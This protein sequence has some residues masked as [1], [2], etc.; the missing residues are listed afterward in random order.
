[1]SSVFL[2]SC[3]LPKGPSSSFH[4]S[5]IA[6][7]DSI[8]DHKSVNH[9]DHHLRVW[10]YHQA[11][12]PSNGSLNLQTIAAQVRSLSLTAFQTNIMHIKVPQQPN[13]YDCGI[14]VVHFA[15]TFFSD[16]ETY[17]KHIQVIH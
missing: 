11:N 6:V 8:A 4:V 16:A 9:I 17:T 15:K 12:Q 7:F 1:M 3:A 13:G 14:Y 5:I 10:L 2:C